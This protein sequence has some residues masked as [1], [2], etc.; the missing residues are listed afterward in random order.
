MKYSKR[1]GWHLIGIMIIIAF[2]VS[3]VLFTVSENLQANAQETL[4]NIN[5]PTLFSK[6]AFASDRSGNYDI[7]SMNTDGG[8]VTR[9]TT[10]AGDNVSPSWAPDGTRIAFVS[11][12]DG[13]TEIYVMNADG[14]NQTRLTNNSFDDLSP[15]FSPDGTKI[16]FVSNSTG[17][18]QIFVMNADGSN[19]TNISNSPTDDFGPAW[20][21]D[22]AKLAFSSVRDGN[23][24]IYSMDANGNNQT[25]LTNNADDDANP[26]WSTGKIAFDSFRDSNEQIYVMNENG[27]AQVRLTNNNA[28]DSDPARSVDG[29][30]IV[31][32]STR[33]GNYEVYIANADGSAQAR[34]TNDP[35]SDIEPS[36]LSGTTPPASNNTV[37]FSSATYSVLENAGSLNVMVTRTGDTSAPATVELT[38][39]SGTASDRS[40]FT[41][42]LR[43]LSFAAGETS[44]T[45]TILIIDDAF[46]E[47]DE[48][49]NVTLDTPAGAALGMPSTAT[50]TIIDND[51]APS[52]INPIDGSTFFVRQQYLD[53]L[54]RMPDDAGQQ[55]WV[56]QLN[57]LIASCPPGNGDERRKCVLGQ[58]AQVSAAFFLSIEF[59]QTG[60]F[61]IR[62]YQSAFNRFPTFREFL[63][64]AQT[65]GD[66]VVVGAPG[67]EQKLEANKVAFT[68]AFVNRAAFK[69]LYDSKSNAE[70]LNALFTNGGAQASD[71]T[72]LRSQLLNGLNNNTETRA[73]VLPKVN[74]AKT[75]F[76]A[77][78][79]KAFVLMQYFG[80]LRR[81]PQDPPDMNLDGY[82]FWLNKLNQFTQ[83]G[84]DA[85][86]DGGLARVRR[87]QMIEAFIDS[88]EYRIRFG[89]GTRP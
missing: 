76:N 70:Y 45:V 75:I 66:G 7:Y 65:V 87:A 43:T 51:T 11:G 85:Q 79:N 86:A 40:D 84:E 20:R 13:N 61:V 88:T 42:L 48:T 60:Y 62:F 23:A 19:Q 26:T 49:F 41:P 37:Q 3:G 21:P 67:Y 89:V 57:N 32:S 8:G 35:S 17:H 50:V 46:V 9:L 16:A 83:V 12:R 59:Q 82:N 5:S 80:Y 77:Q 81:N 29:A 38:T 36:L 34:L 55:F 1:S 33:D 6:I 14:G 74:D 44:K 10:D 72:A 52:N 63:R 64:D 68:S 15:A 47:N 56:T 31:F 58:R 25:R 27:S 73:T 54:S 24:E 69:A 71:E 53:F 4:G 78:Y 22:G 2:A 30:Q 18:D 28:F 39:V